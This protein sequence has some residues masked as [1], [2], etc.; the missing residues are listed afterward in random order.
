MKKNRPFRLFHCVGLLMVTLL[1]LANSSN[2]PTGRTGAPFDGSCNNCHSGGGFNGDVTI[3]G[4]PGTVMPNVVYPLQITMS[5][6]VGNPIRGGFQLVAVD[7]N[8]ANT[9]DLAA[10]NAQAGTDMAGGREYLEHRGAKNF[11]GNPISWNFNWTSPS[12]ASGNTI[13]F[14]FIGNFT[15]GNGGTSGDT[16]LSFSETYPFVGAPSVVATIGNTTDVSCN[17]GSDGSATVQPNGGNLPYTYLWS[18]N[19]TTQT[20]IN[21]MANSYTVTVTGSGGSGTATANVFITQPA[22]I[23]ATTNVNGMLDCIQNSVAVTATASG[24]M[25]PYTYAWSNNTTVNPTNYTVGGNQSVVVTDANGCTQA[26]SFVISSSTT[27]PNASATGGTLT[28]SQPTTTIN[29]TSSTSGAA[30]A[31]S[32]PNGFS[33]SQPTATVTG[34]GTYTVTVTNPANGCTSTTTAVVNQNTMQPTVPTTGGSISCAN[35]T[36][37]LMAGSN[38]PQ[39]SFLWSGPCITAANQNQQNP[40]VNCGG[41]FTVVVTNPANG[42]TNTGTAIVTQ[43]TTPPTVSVTSSGS[44]TCTTTSVAV[45]ATTNASNPTFSWSGPGGFTAAT[46]NIN[47]Q[48]PGN[49]TVTVTA[50]SSGCTATAVASVVQDIATTSVIAS[51]SG[52]LTCAVTSVAV[53]TNNMPNGTFSWSGPGGF[54]AATQTINVQV[55][56]NYTVTVTSPN[57]GCTT[58][59]TTTVVQNFTPPTASVAPSGPLTC[60]TT[61]VAVTT[62]TNALNALFSWSGPGGFTAAT[63]NINVQVPGSYTVTVTSSSNGCTATATAT[64]VQNTALPTI[65]IAAPGSLD[66]NHPTIQLNAL[67]SAQGNNFGYQWTTAN[68]N[69]VGGA[70]TL[71][72]TVSAAGMYQLLITNTQSGCTANATTVV[73]QTPLVNAT[74]IGSIQVSCNG[75]NNGSATVNATG[76][77]GTSTILWSNGATTTTIANLPAGPYTVTITDANSC[78]ATASVT[79]TQPTVLAVN[80]FATAQTA[81][82]VNNGTATTAPTGGTGAYTYGWSGTTVATA[83]ITGLAPGNYTVT[84]TDTQGCTAVQTVTVNSVNCN[85]SAVVTA[86]QVTCH[87]A[88]NGSATVVLTGA[89]LPVT[90][91]WSNG[92]TTASVNGL[93]PGNYTVNIIDANSCP[94]VSTVSITEPAALAANAT[95][96][97]VTATNVNDGQA[98]TQPTGGMLPYTYLWS[99]GA[100]TAFISSLMPGNYMVVVTDANACTV[101]QTVTVNAFSCTLTTNVTTTPTTCPEIANGSATV[102]IVGGSAPYAYLW[103]NGSTSATAANLVAGSHTLTITDATGCST[104]ATATIVVLDTIVPLLACSAN[105]SLCGANLVSYSPPAVTDNC[106]LTGILPTLVSGQA[107]GTAFDDGV[108]IQVFLVTDAAGNT[109]TCSFTITVFPIPDILIDSIHNDLNNSGI[110]SIDIT[111]VGGLAPYT[112]IWHKDGVFFSNEEDLTALQMGIYMLTIR[113]TNGCEGALAPVI[114]DNI[115]GTGDPALSQSVRIWPNPAYTGIWVTLNDLE[116]FSAEIWNVQGRLV[117]TLVPSALSDMIGVEHLPNG[118]YYLKIVDTNSK[119]WVAKCVKGD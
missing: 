17:G 34:A 68:G 113:D 1:W 11:A 10:S 63:Q 56:G 117:Q 76:G 55:P 35:P 98:A 108:H 106:S 89:A 93:A 5:P 3:E 21:L 60:T 72:P 82:G 31:W 107:S 29:A 9:G 23:V 114:I 59:A 80:A 22:A 45:L 85:V 27:P 77:T 88:A 43:A 20:A 18:N 25:G 46:Q 87:G 6:T 4:M 116:A 70:T 103:S 119:T 84:V 71:T 65:S 97:A 32:G 92:A 47:V 15:N 38:A 52:P 53:T 96:T 109:A 58:S 62:T 78:T 28:C 91:L 61:S 26:S 54:T 79:I 81:I 42:C 50:P 94:A 110:G 104:T 39:A 67:A 36:V 44:L 2:P 57:N 51:A 19:Q 99:T 7:G 48:V 111:A 64:V 8:N 83:H 75:G 37:Q 13:K 100:T 24:G 40:V 112:F 101:T 16:P 118:V 30:F 105:I 102:S 49:Y 66:C 90:Y 86:T 115:V 95:A 41:T 14:Y 33:S 73:I 12:S 74:I 69:L